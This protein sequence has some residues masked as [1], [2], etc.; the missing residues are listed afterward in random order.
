MS[1]IDFDRIVSNGGLAFFTT[2]AGTQITGL[3]LEGIGVSL[4]SAAITGGLALFTEW[5]RECGGT[6]TKAVSKSLVV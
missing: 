5:N 4:I 1:K 2:L 6:I 3:G